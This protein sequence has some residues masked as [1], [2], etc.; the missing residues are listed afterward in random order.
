MADKAHSICLV[1]YYYILPALQGTTQSAA[2][3]ARMQCCN[4]TID[5]CFM[6]TGTQP[7]HQV[8]ARSTATNDTNGN[9]LE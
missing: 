8:Y 4:I 3:N 7:S 1:L 5:A 9:K 2:D 6:G